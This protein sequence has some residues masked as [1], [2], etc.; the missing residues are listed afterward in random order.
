LFLKV[1]LGVCL[2]FLPGVGPRTAFVLRFVLIGGLAAAAFKVLHLR[3]YVHCVDNVALAAALLSASL[4]AWLFFQADSMAAMTV[5]YLTMPLDECVAFALVAL[6]AVP[7]ALT[8]GGSL[9]M[10]VVSVQW[11]NRSYEKLLQRTVRGWG[12]DGESDTYNGGFHKDD[13]LAHNVNVV[14]PFPASLKQPSTSSRAKLVLPTGL[15]PS[16]VHMEMQAV[17]T[18]SGNYGVGLSTKRCCPELPLP[19]NV[20]FPSSQDRKF[21]PTA[22]PPFAVVTY[23]ERSLLLFAD[24][25]DNGGRKWEQLLADCFD[26]GEERLGREAERALA[27]HRRGEM[28]NMCRNPGEE[29][30]LVLL[31][32]LGDTR[33]PVTKFDVVR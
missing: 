11:R 22:G 8:L 5:P 10:V 2:G 26:A 24:R 21:T 18:P 31:E 3:P 12:G 20:L 23:R 28:A 4:G 9:C 32:I 1:C 6:A 16:F 14:I 27:Q 30:T 13:G 17:P 7:L 15:Q 19:V 29:G 33:P 25:R